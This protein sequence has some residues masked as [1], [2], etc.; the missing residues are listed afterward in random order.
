MRCKYD[1]PRQIGRTRTEQ[2]KSGFS[3]VLEKR[4]T[5]SIA[6]GQAANYV[7]VVPRQLSNYVSVV[8]AYMRRHQ[9]AQKFWQS[10]DEY[11][12]ILT[13]RRLP[14]LFLSLIERGV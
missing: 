6:A 13:S 7:F 10:A 2:P 4:R 11:L 1:V 5:R 12:S 8:Q 9:G 14:F 3:R